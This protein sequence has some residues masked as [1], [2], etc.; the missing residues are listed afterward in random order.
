MLRM[1]NLA[2][3]LMHVFFLNSFCLPKTFFP[4][5]HFLNGELVP[6]GEYDPIVLLAIC[7]PSL[8]LNDLNQKPLL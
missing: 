1:N 7:N 5:F 6:D 8:G 2:L 3:S 4:R